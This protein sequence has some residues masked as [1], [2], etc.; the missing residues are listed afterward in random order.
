MLLF[1]PRLRGECLARSGPARKYDGERKRNPRTRAQLFQPTPITIRNHQG[2]DRGR[3][4]DRNYGAFDQYPQSQ[5]RPPG[6]HDMQREC[7]FSP[8]AY[9]GSASRE[10]AQLGSMMA[11]ESEIP[12]PARNCFSQRQSRSATTRAAIVAAQTIAITG[13]LISTP[14]PNAA[15][16]AST[17][18]NANA[19]FL[20]PLTGGVPRAKRP[21]SEV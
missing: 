21:S 17:T 20:P 4:D 18:C 1:S 6:K 14:N 3:A 9:G 10:A 19:P 2:R 5:R 13:P 12:V 15:H 7:S 16:P 11:S 8:P